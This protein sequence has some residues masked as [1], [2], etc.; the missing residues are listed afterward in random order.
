MLPSIENPLG[1][2]DITNLWDEEEDGD[3]G[4]KLSELIFT[5]QQELDLLDHKREVASTESDV[6]ENS[7]S[8]LLE[9][10]LERLLKQIDF[11][12]DDVEDS[13]KQ[14]EVFRKCLED[15]QAE[16]G[17]QAVEG[18]T[19]PLETSSAQKLAI[20][21]IS[22]QLEMLELHSSDHTKELLAVFSW[23]EKQRAHEADTI[24]AY[25]EQAL[26][27]AEE[28]D[29]GQLFSS[30]ATLTHDFDHETGQELVRGDDMTEEV[31]GA[32]MEAHQ[33]LDA[34]D[35]LEMEMEAKLMG[36][37]EKLVDLT[38]AQR[39]AATR[40]LRRVEMKLRE[41]AKRDAAASELQRTVLQLR[42]QLESA[43]EEATKASVKAADSVQQ[44][45]TAEIDILHLLKQSGDNQEQVIAMQSHEEKLKAVLKGYTKQWDKLAAEQQRASLQEA[46]AREEIAS[47]QRERRELHEADAVRRKQTQQEVEAQTAARM[48]GGE[49]AMI[50][51]C[52]HDQLR[53]KNDA[54]RAELEEL[55]RQ[56]GARHAMAGGAT[57]T[58]PEQSD[59]TLDE[60]AVDSCRA[61][62]DEKEPATTAIGMVDEKGDDGALREV[63]ARRLEQLDRLR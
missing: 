57:L 54:L 22:Q 20:A 62:T 33:V 44:A 56:V 21:S 1:R 13:V 31:A 9:Q 12:H 37:H 52:T 17:E 48:P 42:K 43:E 34:L 53:A 4:A 51:G 55:M 61:D 2:F 35:A 5:V 47:F 19:S 15:Q 30:A 24:D 39:A 28:A 40:E 45:R 41:K 46:M 26:L 11:S 50:L 23:L 58:E 8:Y 25:R 18:T 32:R 7:S 29:G 38:H 10:R 27:Q 6:E 63:A 3:P 36:F 59:L 60:D 49:V 14:L 16:Q